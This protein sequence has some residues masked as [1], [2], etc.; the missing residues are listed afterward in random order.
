MRVLVIEDDPQTAGYLAKGLGQ[1]GYAVDVEPDAPSGLLRLLTVEYAV[2]IID[3]M[4]PGLDGINL[5]R[6]ARAAEISIPILMLTARTLVDD[7]VAGLRAGADDYLTKPFAFSELLARLEAITKR[8]SRREE[9]VIRVG[10]LVIDVI[11]RRATRAGKEL[12]LQPL[13]FSLLAYLARNRGRVISKTTIAE[14][15]WN[16][17]FDPQTSVV[18][19]RICRLRDKVDKP[20]DGKLI[21]TVRGCG[22]VLDGP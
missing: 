19:T 15:V 18:E 1:E 16:Y 22:Y 3:V 9:D 6:R 11:R 5:V 8:S 2:A 20:F 7:K 14:Q 13:E 17:N 12:Q 4:L 10:D 21:R